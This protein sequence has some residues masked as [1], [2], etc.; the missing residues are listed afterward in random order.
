LRVS[1]TCM[2][3]NLLFALASRLTAE[4]IFDDDRR[5]AK[6]LRRLVWRTR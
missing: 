6:A 2:A 3:S 5:A 1:V 4:D